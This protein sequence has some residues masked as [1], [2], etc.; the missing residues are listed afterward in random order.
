MTTRCQ[1]MSFHELLCSDM[2]EGQFKSVIFVSAS[3]QYINMCYSCIVPSLKA[4]VLWL[5]YPC[6]YECVCVVALRQGRM[7]LADF[8]EFKILNQ[9]IAGLTNFED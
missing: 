1:V 8:S 3:R 6:M 4:Q 5:C 7:A 2:L 9:I